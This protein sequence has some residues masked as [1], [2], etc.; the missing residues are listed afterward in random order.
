MSLKTKATFPNFLDIRI[1]ARIIWQSG[2]PYYFYDIFF[3]NIL[4]P[5]IIR[6]AQFRCFVTTK[7]QF[8]QITHM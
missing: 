1:K 8:N 4:G 2:I 5:I 7:W 3:I 6:F